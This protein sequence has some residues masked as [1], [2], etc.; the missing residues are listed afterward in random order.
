MRLLGLHRFY[1]ATWRRAQCLGS[2]EYVLFVCEP[3]RSRV[4]LT[5]A[6]GAAR[7]SGVRAF[8]TGSA[9]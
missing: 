4:E 2:R 9:H 7:H 1:I 8:A 5:L 6:R 3:D